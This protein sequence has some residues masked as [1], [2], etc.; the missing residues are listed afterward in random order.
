M[1]LDDSR[2]YGGSQDMPQWVAEYRAHAE[3]LYQDLY[4]LVQRPLDEN[5]KAEQRQIEYM[6]KL[7]LKELE[8]DA[9]M[10]CLEDPTSFAVYQ[11]DSTARQAAAQGLPEAAPGSAQPQP[12]AAAAASN[13]A[14][15]DS[16]V[17][18]GYGQ[19]LQPSS[20]EPEVP[21]HKEGKKRSRKGKGS[22]SRHNTRRAVA[23]QAKFAQLAAAAAASPAETAA[24]NQAASDAGRDAN[25]P[26]MPPA[27]DLPTSEP[28]IQMDDTQPE[29]SETA[30]AAAATAAEEEEEEEEAQKLLR[31]LL[32]DS[33][34]SDQPL[35]SCMDVSPQAAQQL[36]LAAPPAIQQ[37]KHTPIIFSLGPS[38]AAAATEAE[39]DDDIFEGDEE[40]ERLVL[41][42]LEE[43]STHC[44]ATNGL[45]SWAAAGSELQYSN[46]ATGFAAPAATFSSSAPHFL[47]GGQQFGISRP[48]LPHTGDLP[49]GFAETQAAPKANSISC[50]SRS[51]NYDSSGAA[52]ERGYGA[53]Y[54]PAYEL[55]ERQ[56]LQQAAGAAWRAAG[57]PKLPARA[58]PSA[59]RWVP[60][61]TTAFIQSTHH[62]L[63]AH[64]L[65][66]S[67]CRTQTDICLFNAKHRRLCIC[68][69]VLAAQA[70][71]AFQD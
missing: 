8:D 13:Q 32:E 39:E 16:S 70:T 45:S 26:V 18:P 55:V 48:Q 30:T 52:G 47:L 60:V 36:G 25:S 40:A 12:P 56:Q 22:Q 51:S 21:V 42:I 2:S 50:S 61:A 7:V 23:H 46:G 66:C 33:S 53:V 57:P 24:V 4:D 69:C 5:T 31:S 19:S 27:G 68:I 54:N 28:C 10:E 9:E 34:W 44:Q 17:E 62:C 11:P 67:V 3:S 1:Q 14:D 38:A 63:T 6:L 43:D 58:M 65:L 37:P 59:P 20:K 49:A 29:E 64:V 15:P 35:T 71:W 41:S